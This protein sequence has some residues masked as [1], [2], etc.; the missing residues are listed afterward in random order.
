MDHGWNPKESLLS[1]KAYIEH[2]KSRA[3][4]RSMERRAQIKMRQKVP[5]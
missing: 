4:L 2:I 1:S 3:A 5:F